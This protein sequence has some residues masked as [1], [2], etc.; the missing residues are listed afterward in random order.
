MSPTC[1]G[2]IGCEMVPV[3]QHRH[4]LARKRG[5]RIKALVN[6]GGTITR[7]RRAFASA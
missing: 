6:G 4:L 1:S 2:E 3:L 7:R 5:L